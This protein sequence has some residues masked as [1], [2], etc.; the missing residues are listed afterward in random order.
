LATCG[1]QVVA[2]EAENTL[3]EW[4]VTQHRLMGRLDAQASRV[5]PASLGYGIRV[6][7]KPV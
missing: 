5:L 1:F 2:L 4:L 7:A 6:V 3:P